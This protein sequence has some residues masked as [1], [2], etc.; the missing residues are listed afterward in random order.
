MVLQYALTGFARAQLYQGIVDYADYTRYTYV[1]GIL[2]L[3]VIGTVVGVVKV[4]EAGRARLATLAVLG[5]WAAIGLETNIGFLIGGRGLFLERADMTRALVTVAL[6]A[7]RPS[8]VDLDRSLVLVPSPSS[9]ERISAA[10]GDPRTD[11]LVPWAVRPIP[12][13]C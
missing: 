4:P 3:V 1:S 9:L 12:P 13:Q 6:A 8:G 5:L 7:D 11:R 10:Y 2:A